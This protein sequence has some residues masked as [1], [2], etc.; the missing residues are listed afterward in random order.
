[1]QEVAEPYGR[2]GVSDIGSER[3]HERVHK[4]PKVSPER[5]DKPEH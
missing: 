5:A 4:P 1:M 2:G 3:P